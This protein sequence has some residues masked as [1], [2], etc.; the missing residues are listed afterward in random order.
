MDFLRLEDVLE[1]LG[2][3][4]ATRDQVKSVMLFSKEG[5][6]DLEGKTIGITDDTATSVQLLRVLLEKK[7]N[8][9]ATFERL[10]AGVNDCSRFDA[11]LLIGDEAL[12]HNKAGLDGFELVFDLASEWYEWQKLP[13]VFAVWA[14]RKA[15][16]EES[17]RDLAGLLERSLDACGDDFASI[18]GTHGRRI[19]LTEAETQEYLEGFNYKLGEREREAIGVFRRFQAELA[20]SGVGN[21]DSREG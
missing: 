15:L 7:Y 12:R 14:I 13:F 10:H 17:R 11:V 6:R 1:P 2:W 16:P 4:I 20:T 18:A 8:V 3:C 5:W 21:G 9:H 19:G